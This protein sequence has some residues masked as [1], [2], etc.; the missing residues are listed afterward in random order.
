MAKNELPKDAKRI[1]ACVSYC[2]V[3]AATNAAFAVDPNGNKAFAN[4]FVDGLEL[5]QALATAAGLKA[6]TL[7]GLSA[8]ARAAKLLMTVDL[9]PYDCWNDGQREFLVSF[10]EDMEASLR[11]ALDAEYADK[12]AANRSANLKLVKPA[13]A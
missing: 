3:V 5:H 13:A 4:R 10:A 12:V 9:S 6:T 8:K 7:A 1:R 11:K 2:A